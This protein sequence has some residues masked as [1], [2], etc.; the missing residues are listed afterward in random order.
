MSALQL[1]T[2]GVARLE[3]QG[4]TAKLTRKKSL[5]TLVYLALS[6]HPCSR[7]TLARMFWPD[8]DEVKARTAL[9]S[10][11]SELNRVLGKGWLDQQSDY[12]Q[13]SDS[14]ELSVDVIQLSQALSNAHLTD[15]QDWQ[16]WQGTFMEGFSLS[17]CDA[18]EEWQYFQREAWRQ[19]YIELLEG[20][21][22]NQISQ[23]SQVSLHE[24]ALLL[25]SLAPLNEIATRSLMR[26]AFD[27]G[28]VEQALQ[29]YQRL[30]EALEEEVG[31]KPNEQTKA[32]KAAIEQ[33][34]S[35][36]AN[37]VISSNT[38][39]LPDSD[40]E[41]ASNNGVHLAYRR[42]GQQG[43]VLILVWGF[44]SHLD[45]YLELPKLRDFIQQ[46]SQ[47]FRLVLFDKRGMGLSD[48]VGRP[49]TLDETASDIICLLDHLNIEQAWI[50]GTSE[51][52]PAAIKCAHQ[53]PQRISHLLLYGTAAKWTRTEDYPYTLPET[54]YLKWISM[55]EQSW[56]KVL[57]LQQ[58]APN[59]QNDEDLAKWWAKNLRLAAS[60]GSIRNVL[61]AAK[62]IDVRELLPHINQPSIVIQQQGD[63]LI[64][65][66]NG[67]YLAKHL[68]NARYLEL[69]GEDHWLWVGDTTALFAFIDE[70]IKQTRHHPTTS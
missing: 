30:E 63:Q 55:L 64:R 48:R 23:T 66:E 46:L 68:P 8:L 36:Q 15:E 4:Q 10:V 24:V 3:Q 34:D 2:L 25:R 57:N 18:F 22:N 37:S 65:A 60:P 27:G 52:G 28:H 9:R 16:H 58:F 14:L 69:P 5:A 61:E 40:I 21:L 39:D 31:V 32:L 6:T 59:H 7:D 67:R 49:P 43:P 54:L 20:I 56:G 47:R 42:F 41:Y 12:L 33:G 44:V 62:D 70:L 29:Y 11:L 35:T 17:D 26:Q 38:K 53:Y 13:I 19:R 51:G 45:Q 50:I 1:H